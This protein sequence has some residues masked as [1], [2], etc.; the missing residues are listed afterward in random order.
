MLDAERRL[1][2]VMLDNPTG[3]PQVEDLR[4][5]AESDRAVLAEKHLPQA[6]RSLEA[7]AD[8]AARAGIAIGLENRLGY[9]EI[10]RYDETA[11]LLT[12]YPPNVVGYWHDI[13]HAE[14]QHRLG[15]V[16][17]H[18]WLDVNGPRAIG[19]HLHDVSKIIDHRAPGEGDV[20]WQYIIDGLPAGVL[21]TFEINQ[22][23]DE[24]LLAPA[25]QLLQRVGLVPG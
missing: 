10:P 19:S 24:S 25:L 14:V 15:L 6:A 11:E 7:L 21:R 13:G 18:R 17:K 12:H 23:A 9:H 8:Y 22:H 20:E 1:R 4:R 16:D 3:G 2:A 5:Q